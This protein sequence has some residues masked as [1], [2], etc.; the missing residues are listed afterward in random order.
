MGKRY[1]HLTDED[2]CV[3]YRMHSEGRSKRFIARHLKRDPSTISRELR[4]NALPKSGY[5]PTSAARMAWARRWRG[6]KLWRSDDLRQTILDRLAMGWSPEI[7]AGRLEHEQG[8][9]IISH[10][11]IYRFIYSPPGRKERLRRYLRQGKARRGPRPKRRGRDGLIPC[12]T[13][14]HE[15]PAEVNERKAFGH[16]EGDLMCFAARKHNLLCLVERKSRLM[17]AEPL[18]GKTAQT[19]SLSI[20]SAMRNLPALARQSF[21]FDNGLEFAGHTKIGVKAYFCDPYAPWQKGSVENAIGRLRADMPRKTPL[22]AY[23]E[24]DIYD[25]I[26]N[27]NDT[28][29]KCLGFHTPFEAFKLHLTENVALQM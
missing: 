21:S 16:W 18:E 22:T 9:K 12:R 11:S 23:H 19:V 27:Y 17:I 5:L 13:S 25:L 28:P 2:R 24:R 3:I 10:E 7:I 29:R 20:R 8:T 4:R 14:I 1:R 26:D 15:R 6:S